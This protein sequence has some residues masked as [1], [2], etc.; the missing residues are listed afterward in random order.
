M[1][2]VHNQVSHRDAHT[3]GKRLSSKPRID[4]D[5]PVLQLYWA[6]LT[7]FSGHIRQVQEESSQVWPTP[8]S[9]IDA[10]HSVGTTD[11]IY[12]A[13]GVIAL[14]QTEGQVP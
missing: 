3:G 2:Y 4:T 8:E 13:G 1:Q 12:Y 14:L 5:W 9:Y 10:L 6:L 11:W 7:A